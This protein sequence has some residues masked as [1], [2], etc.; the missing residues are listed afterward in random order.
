MDHG[1]ETEYGCT[2]NVEVASDLISLGLPHSNPVNN[3]KASIR[4]KVME[5]IPLTFI[6]MFVIELST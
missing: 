2:G 5:T 6:I 3:A 4:N 1:Q